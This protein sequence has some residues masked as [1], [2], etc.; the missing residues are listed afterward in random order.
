MRETS[1]FGGFAVVVLSAVTMLIG[2]NT[3]AAEPGNFTCSASALRV[4]DQVFVPVN[5]DGTRTRRGVRRWG[6]AS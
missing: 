5:P 2:A 3:A 6:G 1:L 4:G